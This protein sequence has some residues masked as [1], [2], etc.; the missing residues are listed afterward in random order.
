MMGADSYLY[1]LL[2]FAAFGLQRV[3]VIILV[4]MIVLV[5]KNTPEGPSKHSKFYLIIAGILNTAGYVPLEVWSAIFGIGRDCVFVVAS[6]VD[7][8]HLVYF[9]S[10]IFFFLFLRSEY[11]RNMEECIW[12]T[13]THIQ[14]TFDFRRF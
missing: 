9:T 12:E 8:I 6:W 7:L 2:F 4:V 3:P 14:G 13:V 1:E 5:Q 11:L 10:L